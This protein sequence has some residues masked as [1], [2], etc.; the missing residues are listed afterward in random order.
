MERRVIHSQDLQPTVSV[1]QPWG[2]STVHCLMMN[3]DPTLLY[4]M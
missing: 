2:Y 3:D 4:R 1:E